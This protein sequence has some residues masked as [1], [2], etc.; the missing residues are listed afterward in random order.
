MKK[1]FLLIGILLFVLGSALVL[2][3]YFL[4]NQ[5]SLSGSNHF[6]NTGTWQF[7]SSPLE[8]SQGDKV[9]VTIS[10]NESQSSTLSIKNTGG[11]QVFSS[12]RTS[13]NKTA[14][15]YV[16]ANDFYFC[17]LYVSSISGTRGLD[18]T[19]YI[20]VVRNS[21]HFFFLVIGIIVLLAGAV[22]VPIAFLYKNKTR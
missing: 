6:K 13:G 14:Y 9:T 21:P 22:T 10:M 4:F 2:G 12:T 17:S 15:Y 11:T 19:Y 1:A 5:Y 16:Q 20:E 8:L 18:V 7:P 3:A